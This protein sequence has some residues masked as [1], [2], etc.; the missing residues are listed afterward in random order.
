MSRLM[1]KISACLTFMQPLLQKIV[2]L[3]PTS[4]FTGDS[5]RSR[6]LS[7]CVKKLSHGQNFEVYNDIERLSNTN[8]NLK[9]E[10]YSQRHLSNGI[11]MAYSANDLHNISS[12]RLNGFFVQYVKLYRAVM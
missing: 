6:G 1:I 11:E 9:L 10:E 3:W 7:T 5:S 4:N 8:S 12:H 2:L